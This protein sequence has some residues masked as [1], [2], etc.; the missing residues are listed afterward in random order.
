MNVSSK[1]IFLVDGTGAWLSG[2]LMGGILPIFQDWIGLPLWVFFSLSIL[3]FA[4]GCYSI[5]CHWLQLQKQSYFLIVIIVL[6]VF[7]CVLLALT[8]FMF[9]NLTRIGQAYF[10]GEILVILALVAVEIKI[11]RNGSIPNQWRGNE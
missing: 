8:I 4:Y 2:F 11:Y 6:N 3:G 5:I 7:Y 9:K 10:I 1:N